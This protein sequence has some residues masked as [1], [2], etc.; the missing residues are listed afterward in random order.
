MVELILGSGRNR[1]TIYLKCAFKDEHVPGTIL[2][3]LPGSVNSV[4]TTTLW[5]G[6]AHILAMETE[7]RS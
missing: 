6:T 4:F 3:H 5:V 1:V 2:G 7:A